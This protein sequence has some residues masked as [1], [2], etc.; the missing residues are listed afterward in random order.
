MT[1]SPGNLYNGLPDI[2]PDE[3]AQKDEGIVHAGGGVHRY[4]VYCTGGAQNKS[5]H[6]CKP[7]MGQKVKLV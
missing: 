7:S 5:K 2:L 4:C 1:F 6:L 3:S